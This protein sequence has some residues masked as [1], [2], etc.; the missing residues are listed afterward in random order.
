MARA[1]K[2]L[3]L[4]TGVF[5]A[6]VGL[7]HLS[8]GIG[9]VPG[10]GSTGATVDSR[11]R[12][13]GA[14]F[15]GYGVAW[16]WAARQVPISAR[17]VYWLAGVLLLGGVGRLLSMAAH[18]QPHWFQIPLTIAEFV[19]P[20]ILFILAAVSERQTTAVSPSH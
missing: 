14:I 10:E 11:E 7:F 1:L 9:S 20:P 3:L 19:L 6:A 15:F 17:V 12:F 13:Y 5:C 16:I 18:G 8:L 4:A 2:W